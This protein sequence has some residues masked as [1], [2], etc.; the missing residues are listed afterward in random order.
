MTPERT[1]CTRRKCRSSPTTSAGPCTTITPSRRTCS[2]PDTS[3]V[4]WTRARGIPAGHCCAGIRPRSAARG[5]SLGSPALAT[6][7]A[8]RTSLGST[9]SCPI[10]WTGFGR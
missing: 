2:A 5:R 4:G 6:D 8:K 3:A 7:V 1:C 9:R 10:T